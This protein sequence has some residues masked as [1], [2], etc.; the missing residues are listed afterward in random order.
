VVVIIVVTFVSVCIVIIV[1]TDWWCELTLFQEVVQFHLALGWWLSVIK[2]ISI[3]LM[4]MIVVLIIHYSCWMLFFPMFLL[5]R[6]WLLR[7]YSRRYQQ[8][9]LLCS[10]LIHP[11]YPLSYI[12][13]ILGLFIIILIKV[14]INRT[15]FG[16]F[17]FASF[18]A[19]HIPLCWLL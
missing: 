4:M 8:Q 16:L 18:S 2:V 14:S 6:Q 11:F 7:R 12:K 5:L 15:R 1:M 9:P 19:W 13:L 10:L 17:G 3:W